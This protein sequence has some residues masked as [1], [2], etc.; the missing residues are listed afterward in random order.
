MYIYFYKHQVKL[1]TMDIV[2]ASIVSL[3]MSYT[4]YHLYVYFYKSG[5]KIQVLMPIKA[6]ELSDSEN[7]CSIASSNSIVSEDFGSLDVNTVDSVFVIEYDSRDY[8]HHVDD[9]CVGLPI[10]QIH[11]EIFF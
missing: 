10:D 11:N 2:K 1:F 8:T 6:I 3:L 7:T 4:T 9:D 5:K